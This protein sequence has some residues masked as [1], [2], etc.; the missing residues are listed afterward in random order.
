MTKN[1]KKKRMKRERERRGDIPDEE[2][3][4]HG[5]EE[6]GTTGVIAVDVS[7]LVASE[8]VQSG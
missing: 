5:M 1:R 7:G 6:G 3:S 2:Q 8:G 4:E